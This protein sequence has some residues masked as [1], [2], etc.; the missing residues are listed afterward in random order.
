MFVVD[1]LI[2][3][4]LVSNVFI[5]K[6]YFSILLFLHL[7]NGNFSNWKTETL[8]NWVLDTELHDIRNRIKPPLPPGTYTSLLESNIG[9]WHGV[10]EWPIWQCLLSKQL[11]TTRQISTKS[12]VTLGLEEGGYCLISMH[13]GWEGQPKDSPQPNKTS[14]EPLPDVSFLE[15]FTLERLQL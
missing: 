4:I 8:I 12:L 14:N 11:F 10:L 2:L 13:E 1:N 15:T 5:G 7:I 6:L 9:L 3:L